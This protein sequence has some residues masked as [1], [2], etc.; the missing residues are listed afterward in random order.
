DFHVTGVQT[1]ALPILAELRGEPV[2]QHV[3]PE[4]Q[5]PIAALIPE[6]YVP[7]VHQRLVFY[8]R[9]SQAPDEE[10]LEELRAELVDRYGEVP[11]EVDG[12]CH[13]TSIKL[14]LR[15]LRLRNLDTGAA[16]L[17]LTLGPDAALDPMLLTRMVQS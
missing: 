5:L 1:C 3:E 15:E 6:D 10:A 9:F 13:Q 12:L 17:V 11:D 2:Q 14:A 8:K 7:D 16:R 4:V